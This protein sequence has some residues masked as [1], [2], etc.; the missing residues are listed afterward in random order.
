[1]APPQPEVLGVGGSGKRRNGGTAWWWLREEKNRHQE[2]QERWRG[3]KV[4]QVQPDNIAQKEGPC[5]RLIGSG[6]I[7]TLDSRN[8][9]CR[10]Y[11]KRFLCGSWS[12]LDDIFRKST[13]ETVTEQE[14]WN[15]RMMRVHNLPLLCQMSVFTMLVVFRKPS[16]HTH[17]HDTT[18]LYNFKILPALP[19][20]IARFSRG[21]FI[22][23]Y[24]RTDTSTDKRLAKLHKAV[25]ALD[26][27]KV[28]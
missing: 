28:H 1:M 27:P 3:V 9:S 18:G 12:A 10:S 11:P 22:E 17:I 26:L 6:G 19:G 13:R 21:R 24:F 14:K 5:V 7:S 25:L 16:R 2:R 15:D 23:L 20:P 4:G 8:P